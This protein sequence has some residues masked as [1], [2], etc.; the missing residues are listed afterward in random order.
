MIFLGLDGLAVI[1][2]DMWC[3]AKAGASLGLL[4]FDAQPTEHDLCVGGLHPCVVMNGRY[5]IQEKPLLPV[6]RTN[7]HQGMQ[8]SV[9]NINFYKTLHLEQGPRK[10]NIPNSA[11][12]LHLAGLLSQQVFFSPIPRIAASC[13]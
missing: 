13:F 7:E 3:V 6:K 9:P 1:L 8:R 10:Q 2:G 5:S 12:F 4:G 11:G